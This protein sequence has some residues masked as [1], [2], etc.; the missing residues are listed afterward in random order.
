[1]NETDRLTLTDVLN[2]FNAAQEALS[3]RA[4]DRP[5]DAV[6]LRTLEALEATYQLRL[7]AVFEGI[8]AT[9]SRGKNVASYIQREVGELKTFDPAKPGQTIPTITWWSLLNRDRN[10]LAHGQVVPPALS[11][12]KT[13]EVMI[14]YLSM[15]R[16]GRP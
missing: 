2:Q 16:I 13:L 5:R 3:R 7:Y 1:M 12:P 11:L 14:G 6:I 4:D 10:A 15:Q 8:L 9:R